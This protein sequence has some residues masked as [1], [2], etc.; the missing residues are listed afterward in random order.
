MNAISA[1]NGLGTQEFCAHFDNWLA[2]DEDLKVAT[3][4]YD[5]TMRRLAQRDEEYEQA[6]IEW[7]AEGFRPHYC[8]HGTNL[9]V[10]WDPICG[11]CEAALSNEEIAL[12]AAIG[13]V[14]SSNRRFKAVAEFSHLFHA[15]SIR[16]EVYDQIPWKQLYAWAAEPV[17][18]ARDLM[19]AKVLS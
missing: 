6:C 10:D 14:A 19:A 15:E 16:H 7:A 2:G 5:A 13:A 8:I 18:P 11:K 1:K 12:D 9:W 17:Q 3:A 4:M